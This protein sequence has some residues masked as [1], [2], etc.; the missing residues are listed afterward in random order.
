M[1]K[2]VPKSWFSSDYKLLENDTTVTIIDSSW[3]REAAE[4]T[5]KGSTYRVY[6]EGLMSGSFVLEGDG[7]I[8]ARAEKPSAFYRSFVVEHGGKKYTLEAE[9]AMFRK[10]VLS[11]GGQQ[12]GSVY[13]E[14][15]L[16]R[17]AVVAFPEEIPLAVRVFM[18]WLVMIL[19][20]RDS[21]AAA[22]S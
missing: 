22:A 18:F 8:L 13:P 12:I 17:K 11:E 15:A 3:W 16:T 21:D 9:S 7:S 6:R 19:W 20:K 10:F 14:H 5:I 2:A 1:L 4:L